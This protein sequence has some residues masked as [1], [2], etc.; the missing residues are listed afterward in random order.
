MDEGERKRWKCD[1]NGA[2]VRFLGLT[3][4]A[5]LNDPLGRIEKLLLALKPLAGTYA[6]LPPQSMHVTI[7]NHETAVFSGMSNEHWLER[8][9]LEIGRADS[10][11]Q[12]MAAACKS[13]GYA[14]RARCEAL[15]VGSTV[16]IRLALLNDPAPLIR[17]LEELGSRPEP[18]FVFHIT[19]AYRYGEPDRPIDSSALHELFRR[20]VLGQELEFGPTLLCYFPSME[21]FVPLLAE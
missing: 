14:P 17:R 12:Q 9:L 1:E 13:T 16:R 6:P 20:T 8:T 15:E 4:I 7:K 5:M 2:Y 21:D 10:P 3:F 11:L 18:G 19:L